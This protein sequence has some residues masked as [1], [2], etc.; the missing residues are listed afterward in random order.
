VIDIEALLT[1]YLNAETGERIVGEIPSDTG[2]AWV[3]VTLLDGRDQTRPADYLTNFLVQID[4][5]AGTNGPTGQGEAQGIASDVR[6]FLLA[7]PAETFAD[8]VVTN[9]V[10]RGP[11]RIPDTE[12]KPAR[13]RFI[14]E[15]DIDV[16]S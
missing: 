1:T 14:L 16:H 5:Y 12:F 9:V 15:C 13:Q 2:S 7:M 4:C 8:A 6:G 11:R 3:K 10:V